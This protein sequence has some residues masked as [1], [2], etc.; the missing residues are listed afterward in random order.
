M[1]GQNWGPVVKHHFAAAVVVVVVV[2]VV[3][4]VVA[5][6]VAVVVSGI[7]PAGGVGAG[8]AL[9]APTPCA[10]RNCCFEPPVCWHW[11]SCSRQTYS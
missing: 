5:A 11:E 3:D 8:A 2:V 7:E 10:S 9:V 6:V 1:L 4:V